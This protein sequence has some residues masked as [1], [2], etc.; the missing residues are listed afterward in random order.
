MQA[1]ISCQR[2]L[3]KKWIDTA[4]N[5]SQRTFI[6]QLIQTNK[7]YIICINNVVQYSS[8]LSYSRWKYFPWRIQLLVGALSSFGKCKSSQL[9]LFIMQTEQNKLSCTPLSWRLQQCTAIYKQL[10]VSSNSL[11][12][13]DS[14]MCL[15]ISNRSVI[16]V[17]THSYFLYYNSA[18]KYP[19]K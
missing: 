15:S 17:S 13:G 11:K 7:I 6:E 5:L 3:T 12:E 19:I 4:V 1:D 8:S 18:Y 10:K 16:F 9:D 14:T 2:L